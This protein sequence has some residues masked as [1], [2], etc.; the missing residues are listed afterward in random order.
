MPADEPPAPATSRSRS[1][2][3]RSGTGTRPVRHL[4]DGLAGP[5][6]P[7]HH[8]RPAPRHRAGTAAGVVLLGDAAHAMA[9]DL[10]Q[11]GCQALEDALVLAHYLSSHRPRRSPTPWPRMRTSAAPRTAEIVRRARKRADPPTARRPGGATD[12]P[13][14]APSPATTG[15]ASH[16]R[17]GPVGR[18][19]ALPLIP[20]VMRPG[21]GAVADPVPG[22][23]DPPGGTRRRRGQAAYSTKRARAAPR[24]GRPA[25]R[26]CRP[27]DI[28]FGWLGPLRVKHVEAVLQVREEVVARAEAGRAD[29]AHV[30]D[31]EGVGD[32]PGAAAPTSV[33][34]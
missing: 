12:E 5:G 29:E 33:V 15:E 31:V 19:R 28:I 11:G 13:G 25:R 1:C 17:P 24:P 30:V 7:G 27:T 16:C 23:V 34:Q 8:P 20:A 22:D 18:H 4:I 9:P 2:E 32:R 14:I 10:G 26:V 21:R 3:A 6:Q